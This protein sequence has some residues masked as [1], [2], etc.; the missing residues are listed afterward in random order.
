MTKLESHL[1]CKSCK[2]QTVP[3]ILK[4]YPM[5]TMTVCQNPECRMMYNRNH[6]MI[7]VMSIE[8]WNKP[9]EEN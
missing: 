2:N 5:A 8:K 1:E 7:S 4:K 6:V 3:D 9:N